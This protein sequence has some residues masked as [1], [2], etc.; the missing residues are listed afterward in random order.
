MI[1]H[2]AVD[3]ADLQIWFPKGESHRVLTAMAAP[4]GIAPC[5][6]NVDFVNTPCR[7][8]AATAAPGLWLW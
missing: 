3:T 2:I 8:R 5:R 1:K 6:E 7:Y 4:A